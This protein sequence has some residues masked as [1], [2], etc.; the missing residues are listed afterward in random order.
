MVVAGLGK[1]FLARKAAEKV[2]VSEILDLGELLPNGAAAMAPAVGA[3]LMA[4][5][6]LEGRKLKWTL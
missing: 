2:G 1:N 4:A 6:K 5:T 3:A